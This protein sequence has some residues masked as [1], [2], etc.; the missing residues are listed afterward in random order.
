MSKRNNTSLHKAR[1]GR[2]DEFYTRMEYLSDGLAPYRDYL[3]HKKI[4]CCCDNPEQ[5][6]FVRYFAEHFHELE[7][8][9]LTTTCYCA[10]PQI[11]RQMTLFGECDLTSKIQKMGKAE[12]VREKT[13]K[14]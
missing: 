7:L 1:N 13:G 8:A 3:K 10:E 14:R 9:G 4:Y 6:S 5:S 11:C 12:K 2:N